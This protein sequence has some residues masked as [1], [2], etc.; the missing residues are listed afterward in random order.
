[1]RKMGNVHFTNFHEKRAIAIS[2]LHNLQEGFKM[3]RILKL[4]AVSVFTVICIMMAAVAAPSVPASA[5]GF[6]GKGKGTVKNPYLVTNVQQIEEMRNNLSASYKL[7]NNIDM[8]SVSS[9]QPIGNM[10]TPF[11]GTF[12]CD[13]TAD[14]K[15]KYIIK[16]LTIN[17]SPAGATLAEKYSGYKKDG[18]MG[19]EAG[20]FG[21]TKGATLKNIVILNATVTSTVEG[22]S[23]MNSDW[24]TNNGQSLEQSTGILVGTAVNTKI[25]GCGS[26]GTVKSASNNVG[27]LIGTLSA[28]T[29]KT[30]SVKNSYSYADVTATGV[31]NSGG[32]CGGNETFWGTWMGK[33]TVESCFYQGTFSGGY[34]SAGAF[35]GPF[36][37]D[38]IQAGSSIKNCWA[39]GKVLTSSSGCFYGT[40]VYGSGIAKNTDACE[41]CYTTAVIEGRTKSQTNKELTKNNWITDAPGGLEIGFAA[42]SQAEINA[43]FQNLAA[44]TVTDGSFPQLKNVHP[45]ES[46]DGYDP[47]AESNPADS[48]PG[49]TTDGNQTDT[50]GGGTENGENPSSVETPDDG[51]DADD[52]DEGG[53]STVIETEDSNVSLAEKILF[54]VL[55]VI[56]ILLIAATVVVIVRWCLLLRKIRKKNVNQAAGNDVGG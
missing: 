49:N 36:S 20:F 13:T 38:S 17:H 46:A 16:N 24:S 34:T 3:K 37:T 51:S 1:M 9:F 15:P 11:T 27:G 48:N 2:D 12:T 28:E 32:F 7:A 50:A 42:G 31:W 35:F 10:A 14:G 41:N 30:S 5:A 47:I 8:S 45:I 26:S 4:R 44:W 55:A 22:N 39:S 54:L 40:D 21:Q 25:T 6:S 23:S 43:A 52:G 19:W 33:V 18:S 53:V 56:I 29:G